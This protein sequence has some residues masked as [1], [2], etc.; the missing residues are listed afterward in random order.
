MAATVAIAPIST[1]WGTFAAAVTDQGLA[2]LALPDGGV[3]E[4]AAWAQRWAPRARVVPGAPLLDRVAEQ[5]REYL[6]GQRRTFDLP[7]DLRGTPFQRAVWAA[8][9][10]IPYGQ[11]MTY[12]GVAAA[13]GRPGAA[14]AVGAA[15][16][17]NPVA[18]VVPCHRVVAADG[19]GGYGGWLELKR[20]LLALEG[21]SY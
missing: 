7:L 5:L 2:C 3:A 15:C 17:A 21:H 13:V 11:V 14:R 20:R 6:A 4:C 18:V 12:A 8:I 19:L 16:G 1:P 9:A 10:R